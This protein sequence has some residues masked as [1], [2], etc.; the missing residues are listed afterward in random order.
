MFDSKSP[1]VKVVGYIII[2]FFA[3]IIIISFGMPDFIS[4]LGLDQSTIAVVNGEK[5]HILDFLRYRDTRFRNIR[6]T[7]MENVILDYYI[8]DVLLLQEARETG[9][10]PSDER[11]MKTIRDIP[12]LRDPKTGKF[13]PDLFKRFLN[14]NRMSF[15]ELYVLVKKDLIK[16][17]FFQFIRMGT[18]V[19]SRELE[20][21][22]LSRNSRIQVRY[23]YSSVIGLKKAY[24][25]RLKVTEEEITAEMEKNPAEIKDP[26]TDRARIK[27]LLQEK[28]FSLLKKEIIT[29]VNK[30]SLKGASFES[31]VPVLKGS[32]S[33]SNIFKIGEPVREIAGKKNPLSA[34][35]NSS[36]FYEGCLSLNRGQTSRVIE[37]A[38]GLYIFTPSLVQIHSKKPS[39][40]QISE[41]KN[42]LLYQDQ[43]ILAN[44]LVMRLSE[45]SKI[46]K[47]LK[48]D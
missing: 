22:Y 32:V 37:S 9:F 15:K 23:A 11:I 16:S 48:T 47:N 8:R 1:V 38:T 13:N 25:H 28:K 14:S 44:N 30:M 29:R 19:S 41:L 21:E 46:V 26:K 42:E 4:R 20:T 7:K 5:V 43:R 12:G 35:N 45:K 24:R 33:L 34:L 40:V 39:A 31:A 18:G 3:L 36:I 6:D 17:D 2:G 10:E 27:N